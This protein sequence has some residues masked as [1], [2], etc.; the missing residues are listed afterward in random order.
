MC[1]LSAQNAYFLPQQNKDAKAAILNA[2]ENAKSTI[3][4]AMYSFTNKDIAKALRQASK[5]GVVV[6]LILDYSQNAQNEES[7]MNSLAK[8]YR[9][10]VCL[11]S[12][13]KAR[14]YNRYH[15]PNY[16]GLMHHKIMIIDKNLFFTG[17]LNYSANSFSNSYENLLIIDD[18][19]VLTQANAAFSAM[20]EKCPGLL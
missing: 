5:R 1:A 12:G 16:L 3:D 8:L 17:S 6:H 11:L 2:I 4:I 9:V 20:L 7:V 19:G 10:K 13:L 18:P 14:A 15:N